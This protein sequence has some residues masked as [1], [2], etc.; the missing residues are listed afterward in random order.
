MNAAFRI[1]IVIVV[2]TAVGTWLGGLIHPWRL[3][4]LASFCLSG[5]ASY[6]LNKLLLSLTEGKRYGN[7][8]FRD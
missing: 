3:G 2:G 6:L 1:P 5:I 4:I 8:E 7:P